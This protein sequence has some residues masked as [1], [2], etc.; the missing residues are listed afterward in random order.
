MGSLEPRPLFDRPG[1]EPAGHYGS[2][3]NGGARLGLIEQRL[4]AIETEL[5]HIAR[6]SD[7]GDLKNSI[8]KWMIGILL[9]TVLATSAAVFALVRMFWPT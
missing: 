9:T 1:P 4:V 2:N 7:L 5:K 8:L 3:G 6:R